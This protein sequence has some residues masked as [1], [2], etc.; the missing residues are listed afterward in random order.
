MFNNMKTQSRHSVP[1][2]ATQSTSYF[3]RLTMQV[4]GEKLR[5]E[6]G[7]TITNLLNPISTAE[8]SSVVNVRGGR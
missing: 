5:E 3:S 6:E 8:A 7:S 4:H 2:L 1:Q